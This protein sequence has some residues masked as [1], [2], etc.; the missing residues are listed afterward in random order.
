MDVPKWFEF[1][2]NLMLIGKNLIPGV[3]RCHYV[4]IS[5]IGFWRNN[6]SNYTNKNMPTLRHFAVRGKKKKKK[7]PQFSLPR[8]RSSLPV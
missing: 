7:I 1:K 5:K 8:P 6:I 4:L 3:S 2:I